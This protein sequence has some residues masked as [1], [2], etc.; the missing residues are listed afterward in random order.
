MSGRSQTDV[1]SSTLIDQSASVHS[2][3]HAAV[4]LVTLASTVRIQI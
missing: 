3:S 2:A 4:G 1:G